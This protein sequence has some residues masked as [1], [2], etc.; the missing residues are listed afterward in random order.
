MRIL[1]TGAAGLIGQASVAAL[2]RAGLDVTPLYRHPGP[3]APAPDA[4]FADLT[5]DEARRILGASSFDAVV[6]CAAVFPRPGQAMTPDE[7]AL[8]NRRM[9]RCV[10]DLAA[11]RACPLV[12]LSSV[13]VYGTAP[14][15]WRESSA[16]CPQSPYARAKLEGESDCLGQA[17]RCVCLRVSS[18][19]GPGQRTANVLRLFLAQAL[20]GQDIR[21][22]GSCRRTQDFVAASDVA[23][24]V[25]LALV[26][27]RACGIFNIASGVP[28]SMRELALLAVAGVP[29]CRSRVLASG[30]ADP[31]EDHRV[32]VDITKAHVEMGWRPAVDLASGIREWARRSA[33]APC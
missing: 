4:L 8:E 21:F 16:P 28:T 18:P 13:S 15:P 30:E 17:A 2:N 31:Q 23:Q 1:V 25:R 3:H 33:A 9:D 32:A 27:T 29:G 20:Q 5:G 14:L 22:H 10:L 19:Y 6:H 24:A 7:I 26:D 11:E 12:Y